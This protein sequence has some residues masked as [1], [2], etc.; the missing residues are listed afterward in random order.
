MA[1]FKID[2][3]E[4]EA[5]VGTNVLQFALDHGIEVPYYCYHPGL[6]VAGN[7]RMCIVKVMSG[8]RPALMS[9]CTIPVTEGLVVDTKSAD[10]KKAR[11]SV[12]EFQLINHP[13]DCPVCDRAGEC[14]LQDYSFAHGK[15]HSR[16]KEAKVQKH[17]KDLG[18]LIKIWGNRCI[19]CTRCVRFCQEVTGTS[20]LTVVNR[21]D[22]SV[23]DVFPGIPIDN[24]MSLNVVDI[25]PVGA[26]IS[27]DF[28]Y[29]ARVW[30]LD[31]ADSV[32]ATCSRG[33]NLRVDVLED[34]VKR[35]VPRRN[36]P[37]N[38]HWMCDEG[39]LNYKYAREPKRLREFRRAGEDGR[40]SSFTGVMASLAERL[41]EVKRSGGAV[42]GVCSAWMTNEELWL[43][44]K[45]VVDGLGAKAVG[46]LVKPDG[47]SWKAQ[48][49]FRIEADRNPNRRGV[50]A[51]LGKDVLVDGV[52]KVIRVF[53]HQEVALAY[54]ANGIP[55]FAGPSYLVEALRSAKTSVLQDIHDGPLAAAAQVVLPGATPFEKDGT[56]VNVDGR[57]QRLRTACDPP[58]QATRDIEI[59]QALLRG[60][61]AADPVVS[62]EGVFRKVAEEVPAFSGMTYRQIGTQGA[63]PTAGPEGTP[64]PA[65]AANA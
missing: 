61:G 9:S 27:K 26:L 40:K 37:V 15:D 51:I 5:P 13:L 6:S 55:G 45:L 12:L 28:L 3:R 34:E 47:P 16:F 24:P 18:P 64:A 56:F 2:D 1:K 44:K 57:V 4:F 33:C 41:Q 54:V 46:C 32:C 39:R 35:L 20:E 59:Y 14:W 11:E 43:F 25:C 53:K 17:T 48:N 30:H 50:E 52:E 38:G 8:P 31:G 22:R 65:G 49:G 63:M 60:L 7:C 62:A 21:G 36:D 10:V 29:T 23:I 19:V 58:G 42:V